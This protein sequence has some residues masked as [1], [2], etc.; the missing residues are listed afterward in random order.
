MLKYL[1]TLAFGLACGIGGY[2]SAEALSSRVGSDPSM[3]ESLIGHHTMIRGGL[4]LPESNIA[5]LRNL[6]LDASNEES[7]KAAGRLVDKVDDETWQVAR[8]IGGAATDKYLELFASSGLGVG[9]HVDEAL[10]IRER[11]SSLLYLSNSLSAAGHCSKRVVGGISLETL[12]DSLNDYMRI[13]DVPAPILET[14]K[15]AELFA[16]GE[17]I[18][19]GVQPA[20]ASANGSDSAAKMADLRSKIDGIA[21]CWKLVPGPI[22]DWEDRILQIQETPSGLRLRSADSSGELVRSDFDELSPDNGSLRVEDG[23]V[24]G[25]YW[26]WTRLGSKWLGSEHAIGGACPLLPSVHVYERIECPW[27]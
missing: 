5:L 18:R 6:A 25:A 26:T 7:M 22:R 3:E 1:P 19:R 14:L 13:R 21:G 10:T 15:P 2:F 17:E 23:A 24:V 8:E 27:W 4:G 9:R 20:A 11:S 12:Q 16:L